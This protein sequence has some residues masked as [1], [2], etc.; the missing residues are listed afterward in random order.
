MSQQA[1]A[2]PRIKIEELEGG[3][4]IARLAP[5]DLGL[6]GRDDAPE[7]IEL[8]RRADQ[9]PAIRAVVFTGS[10]PSRFI[11]HAEISWL[12][13]DG[14][15][16]PPVSTRVTSAVAKIAH[17][18]ARYRLTRWVAGKTPLLGGIQADDLHTALL[19]MATSS[20]IFVAAL[21]G[22][23]LGVGAEIAWAC[24]LRLMAEGDH[25]IGHLEILMGIIP[26]AGG[27]QRMPRLIG[28]HRA[29]LAILEGRPLPA[30]EALAV[31]AIDEIVPAGQLM[32]RAVERAAYLAARPTE[33]IGAVKR[34][35]NLGSSLSLA[36]GLHLELSEMLASLPRPQAQELMKAYLRDTA[37]NGE[38]PLYQPG[39]YAAALLRGTTATGDK[40]EATA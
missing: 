25:F 5:D 24:D 38:L 36:D 39:G 6:F 8:V 16:I 23:V 34:A 11:S 21:N 37:A 15:V 35:V 26:G 17:W 27:T 19:R 18:A 4:I 20:T 10:H 32:S 33:A 13:E 31:G 28:S 1:A 3:V 29:L 7:F 22:S 2:Q 40:E 9:D 14:A 12:Q 30:E